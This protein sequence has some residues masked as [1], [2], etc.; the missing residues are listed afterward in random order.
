MPRDHDQK[1]V[2]DA[3]LLLIMNR[4]S[5]ASARASHAASTHAP[6]PTSIAR[7]IEKKKE[8]EAVMALERSSALLLRRMEGLSE[9]CETMADAGLGA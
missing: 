6:N 5:V 7:L 4:Q 1:H 9:D 8:L 2:L 3:S